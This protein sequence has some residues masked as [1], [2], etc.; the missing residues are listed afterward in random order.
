VCVGCMA[1]NRHAVKGRQPEQHPGKAGP[2]HIAEGL[3]CS[4]LQATYCLVALAT[5]YDRAQC[6]ILIAHPVIGIGLNL[7][8]EG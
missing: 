1:G 8:W 3:L 6:P 5:M 4:S 2:L 7:E